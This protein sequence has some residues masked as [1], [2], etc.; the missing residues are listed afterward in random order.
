M[1]CNL[2]KSHVLVNP[3]CRIADLKKEKGHINLDLKFFMCY[4]MSKGLFFF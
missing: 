1:D 3:I 2:N 4:K